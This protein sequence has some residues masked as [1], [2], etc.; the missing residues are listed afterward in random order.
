MPCGAVISRGRAARCS[1]P[2]LRTLQRLG[3]VLDIPLEQLYTLAGYNRSEGL[4]ELRE[5]LR[6]KYHLSEE[7]INA[8][9]EAFH[10]VARRLEV[11]P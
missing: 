7:G 6:M 2:A 11:T 9:Q 8:V 5:Y 3:C 1:R 10:S 4:P